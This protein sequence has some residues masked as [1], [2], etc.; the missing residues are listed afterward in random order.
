MGFFKKYSISGMTATEFV[1]GQLGQMIRKL[2]NGGG[3]NV[4]LLVTLTC[5]LQV[6]NYLFA[7]ILI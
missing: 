7:L 4:T 2:V 3:V 1:S 5:Y 6:N